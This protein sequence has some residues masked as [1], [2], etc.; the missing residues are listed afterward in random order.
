MC[1]LVTYTS[2]P[3]QTFRSLSRENVRV[4]GGT[5]YVFSFTKRG[6]N[7]CLAFHRQLNYLLSSVEQQTPVTVVTIFV[8]TTLLPVPN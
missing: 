1:F 7:S 4:N 8:F 5:G 6:E 2:F 3:F